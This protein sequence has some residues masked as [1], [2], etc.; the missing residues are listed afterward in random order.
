MTAPLGWALFAAVVSGTAVALA[1]SLLVRPTRRLAARVR[2]YTV[3]SR[4]SLGRSA[5]VL[6]VATPDAALSGGT[7]RRLFGPPVQ[8]LADRLGRVVDASGEERL[9]LK[10]RQAGLL[11][12]VPV[13][14]RVQDYR[15]RQLGNAAAGAA[16]GVAVGLVIGGSPSEVLVAGALGFVVG[17]TRWRGRL[18]RCIDE[19]RNRMRIE[20]YTINQLL[21]MNVRI[22]GGVIQAVQRVVA[23]GNGAVV[24]E[25]AEVLRAHST[26]L[27]APEAFARMARLTPEPN[28]AR[29]YRLLAAGAEFGAD[30]ADAL[31]SLS[32]DIRD[33]R[34]EALKRTA[35]RRRAAML[36]PIIAILAPVMLLFIAAPLPSLI[37]GVR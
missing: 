37:F 20:L 28:A 34:R 3:A 17:V 30:L 35:T 11:V 7:I 1:T 29:T 6:S 16:I 2:P 13:E 19:R 26:G 12:D 15:V 27:R 14:R 24:D 32:E 22:G 18:D 4:T 10:L 8:A 31:L 33:A 9:L 23:R 21:A 36:L 25:L 5:D